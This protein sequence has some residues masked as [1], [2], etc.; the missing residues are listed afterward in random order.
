MAGDNET[1]EKAPEADKAEETHVGKVGVK[2]T[3]EI[4]STASGEKIDGRITDL[5]DGDS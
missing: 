3:G 2:D 4:V 1:P 5:A